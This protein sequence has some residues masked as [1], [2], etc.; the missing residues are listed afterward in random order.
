MIVYDVGDFVIVEF[1]VDVGF[2]DCL[3]LV[4]CDEVG[5]VDWYVEV[6]V[7]IEVVVVGDWVVVVDLVMFV[8]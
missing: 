2:C 3:V 5:I 7:W 6:V 4:G 8:V 1:D